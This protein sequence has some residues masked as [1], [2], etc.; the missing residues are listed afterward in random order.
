MRSIHDTS[1]CNNAG[2]GLTRRWRSCA[3]TDPRKRFGETGAEN[4]GRRHRTAKELGR[5]IRCIR[6]SPPAWTFFKDL[7]GGRIVG[8]KLSRQA[9]CWPNAFVHY[10]QGVMLM[11]HVA[12]A[13]LL[14]MVVGHASAV[15]VPPDHACVPYGVGF[16][17]WVVPPSGWSCACHAERTHGESKPIDST[18]LP[19]RADAM[20]NKA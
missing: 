8:L 4:A 19:L 20:V 10:L 15:D 16:A 1:S 3:T 5:D 18:Q 13:M 2:V 7:D 9:I 17:F 14:L 11:R 6:R 12:A